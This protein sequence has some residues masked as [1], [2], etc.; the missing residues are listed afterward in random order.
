M[1]PVRMSRIESALRV[2]MAFQQARSRFDLEEMMR[3]VSD[4]CIFESSDPA[5]FGVVYTG[6][7]AIT[8]YWQ[9]FF[10]SS[11]HVQMKAEDI[12][13]MGDHCIL[14]WECVRENETLRG[15]DIFHIKDELIF[16]IFSYA[17]GSFE[18]T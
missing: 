11:P 13:G 2:V 9:N 7:E 17:K 12:F 18:R 15:V 6:K 5:P 16:E 3:L 1:S 10:Q 14:L 8:K 4:D